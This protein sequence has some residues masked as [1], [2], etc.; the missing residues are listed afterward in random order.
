MAPPDRAL[1]DVLS[2]YW[3]TLATVAAERETM[4]I[5]GLSAAASYSASE[6][7]VS[8]WPSNGYA[9]HKG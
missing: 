1:G 3:P 7:L 6:T 5:R 2:A 8:Y 4:P 9:C